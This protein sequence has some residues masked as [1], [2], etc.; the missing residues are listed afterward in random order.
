MVF[1][2]SVVKTR[3]TSICGSSAGGFERE[4]LAGDP[5]PQAELR[6]AEKRLR[7]AREAAQVEWGAKRAGADEAVRRAEAARQI[8]IRDHFDELLGE[9]HERADQAAAEIDS[10]CHSLLQAIQR[11]AL[12]EADVIAIVH[13]AR[14]GGETHVARSRTDTVRAEV[15]RLLA[16]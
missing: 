1:A 16:R 2:L 14:Q 10:A 12:V 4:A 3:A 8:F 6:E 5:P 7:R 15:E 9:E 11:R 13:V